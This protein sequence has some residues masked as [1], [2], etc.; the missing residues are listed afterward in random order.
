M[1]F[2]IITDSN[3]DLG[4]AADLERLERHFNKGILIEVVKQGLA[5]PLT[6]SSLGFDSKA[7]RFYRIEL[8]PGTS[9]QL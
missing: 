7:E 6:T 8:L 2:E 9:H 4:L 5:S 1:R 3:P